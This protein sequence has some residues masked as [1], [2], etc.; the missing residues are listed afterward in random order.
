[1]FVILVLLFFMY[2]VFYFQETFKK[3]YKK[4]ISHIFTQGVQAIYVFD[5]PFYPQSSFRD[6]SLQMYD[7]EHK[8]NYVS[9]TGLFKAE[10]SQSKA[11]IWA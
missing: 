2:V 11:S 6:V 3:K 10:P 7:Q 4:M 5:S 1:M 8:L 9:K